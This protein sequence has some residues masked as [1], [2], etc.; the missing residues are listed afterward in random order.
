[1]KKDTPVE[2]SA[3]IKEVFQFNA[4]TSI[5]FR[6]ELDKLNWRQKL[7]L[8]LIYN[9]EYKHDVQILLST[10]EEY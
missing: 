4:A 7:K 1:M 2:F 8:N 10:H 5:K 6:A 3:S 9:Y